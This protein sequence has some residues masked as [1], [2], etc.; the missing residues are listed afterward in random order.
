MNFTITL[1]AY[2]RIELFVVLFF[3]VS[4]SFIY[5]FVKFNPK[6][7][8]SHENVSHLYPESN[9]DR[10]RLTLHTIFVVALLI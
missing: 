3:L 7:Q 10:R 9:K 1:L 2:C 5:V 8:S 4:V 6:C